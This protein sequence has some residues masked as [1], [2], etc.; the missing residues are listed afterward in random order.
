MEKTKLFFKDNYKFILFLILLYLSLNLKLNFSIYSPGGL[1]NVTERIS[2]TKEI[3]ESSG[4][5]N[6]T[7]VKLIKGTPVTYLLSKVFSSWDLVNDSDIVYDGK[8]LDETIE[9][10]KYYLKES[11]SNA[12][13][14]A[15]DNA[16]VD[17]TI[18]ES[19]NYIVYLSKNSKTNLKLFD[20]I[21][22]YDN[23]EYT[24]FDAMKEYIS[25]KNVGEKIIF[26]IVRDNKVIEA[27]A[28]IINEN[29]SNMVGL[30]LANINTYN[31]D[32]NVSIRLSSTESG[33][34]GGL[35]MSLAIYNAIT[36]SDITKGKIISGTGTISSDGSVGP[37]GGVTYKLRGAY[38][39][40]ADV[41]LVPQDNYEEALEY[42]KK[43]NLDIKLV[44]ISNFK[45]A[46]DYLEKE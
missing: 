44:S 22:K 31:S 21:K 19:N 13:M 10:D 39:N 2:V 23:I 25:G 9:I 33:S 24:S 41:F 27:Y 4:S 16:L 38:N 35:M 32:N 34:S 11:I 36:E 26:S 1:I 18:K 28:Y 6:M 43:Y 14:V 42:K 37:I 45:E 46:I 8:N 5:I 7:Y 12:Y 40:K 15:Y 30:S 17:Y 20:I 29:D 3:Y